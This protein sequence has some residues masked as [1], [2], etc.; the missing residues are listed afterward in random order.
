MTLIDATKN[1]IYIIT[2]IQSQNE[3]TVSRFH[4]L[5]FCPGEKLVLKRKAPLFF[6]K[7]RAPYF[8]KPDLGTDHEGTARKY[9]AR[10]GSTRSGHGMARDIPDLRRIKSN[11]LTYLATER[12]SW[13]NLGNKYL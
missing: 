11:D 12:T 2:D 3:T 7:K 1:K 4:K 8:W 9:L 5:G 6:H 13:V 10:H